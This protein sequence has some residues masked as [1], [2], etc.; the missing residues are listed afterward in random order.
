MSEGVADAVYCSSFPSGVY[1]IEQL[2]ELEN[3]Q[4][5]LQS[6]IVIEC[7]INGNQI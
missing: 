7:C 3:L 1:H 4:G 6:E 5:W 2:F